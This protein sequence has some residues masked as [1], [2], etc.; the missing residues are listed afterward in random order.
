MAEKYDAVIVGSGPNGLTAAITLAHAGLSVL[1]VEGK[2]TPGGGSRT[3]ELTL[4][5]FRHDIC[6]AIHPIGV[7]SPVF[8]KIG[9][10]KYGLEWVN[11]RVPM[12]HPLDD[13]T[14]ALLEHGLE[15]TGDT[16]GPD[17][18]AWKEMM[19]P[20]LKW[21]SDFFEDILRPIRIPKHPLM[22][23]RFGLLGLRS[24]ESLVKSK[25]RGDHARALF[26][27]CAA[28][29]ILPLDGFGTA[30][31]GLVLALAGH[32][33]D[34]P[35]ARGGSSSIIDALI[36]CL[37]SLGGEVE[38]G[39]MIRHLDELPESRVVLFDTAPRHLS[40]IAGDKL[41][42]GYRRKLERFRMGSGVFKIDYALDGPIP[43]RAEGCHRAAT[44]HV[45]GRYE[46]VLKSEH[47]MSHGI[48]PEKPF[49]LVAQQSL[50]DATRAPEGKQTGWAYCHV[51]P[52][53]TVDMTDAIE[54]QIERF[55]PGFRDLILARHTIPPAALER[56]NPNMIGGDIG[57][58][59]NDLMQFIF[60]PFPRIDPYS[61]SNEKIYLCSSSTPPGGGVHGMCGY[62]AAKSALKKVFGRESGL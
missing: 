3:E 27:G 53:C 4:P 58:G 38:T 25:F 51:P 22:M 10:E 18:D 54:S 37:K 17:A 49:V 21:G 14:A 59:S 23:A 19:S 28:H 5:G 60:R 47:E 34:W 29:S 32:A 48:P 20:F 31:F 57:G 39:R 56:H 43:W 7:V 12:A 42:S 15:Q 26:T 40:A 41:S 8:Q 55:A 16:L 24:C 35:C 45:A 61:T 13:G 30:S 62:L 11:A 46:E 36:N 6:G 1:V 44:V 2:E 50:I 9:L 52:G 33:I